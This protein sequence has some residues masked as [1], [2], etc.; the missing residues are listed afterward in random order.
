MKKRYQVDCIQWIKVLFIVLVSFAFFP[1]AK[2]DHV[3]GSDMGYQCLGGGKYKL[4]I[5]FYRDCRGASAPPSWSLLYWYA[6]NN[7]G[8]STSRYSIAMTRTGIRDITPRCSTASSPCSPTNTSYTGDGVEEHTYEANID[9]SKSPFTGVGLG[10]TY[11]FD[12]CIQ[13]VLQ[14]CGNYYGG[15]MGWLLDNRHN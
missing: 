15:Y 5:K 13:S 1:S 10:T 12:I 11:W 8:A 7:Q 6:G 2:A 9:I 3:M 4:I 14:K